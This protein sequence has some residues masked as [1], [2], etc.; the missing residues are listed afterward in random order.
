MLS[1][2]SE[3]ATRLPSGSSMSAV[4]LKLEKGIDPS[5]TQFVSVSTETHDFITCSLVSCAFI[6]LSFVH[7]FVKCCFDV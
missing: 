4:E 6:T 1:A 2:R 3:E 5:E 7:H